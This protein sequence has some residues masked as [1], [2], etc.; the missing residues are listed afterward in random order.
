MTSASTSFSINSIGTPFGDL[1][2]SSSSQSVTVSQSDTITTQSL[3]LLK[4]FLNQASPGI[5]T[6]LPSI[7]FNS[8][9]IQ[10]TQLQQRLWGVREGTLDN[11][12]LIEG[13]G[14]GESSEKNVLSPGKSPLIPSNQSDQKWLTFADGN[15]MWSQAQSV[16]NLPGYKSYA[17]GVQ[18]GATYQ[19]FKGFQVGPYVG[20]QG[21]RVN[22]G[23]SSGNSSAID[24]SVRYGLFAEYSKGGFYAD[25]IAGGAYN[26]LTVNHD[27]SVGNAFSSSA[28]GNLS[29]G[30]FDSLLG[31]GYNFKA[32]PLSFGPMSSLQ[33]TYLNLGSS[34]ETGEG[35]LNLA[36]GSQNAS[37][38]LYTLG[39]QVSAEISLPWQLQ[40][41]PFGSLA[42]QHEFLQDGYTLNYSFL[43][44]NI[45]YQ[46]ANSGRDQYIAALGGN[47]VITRSLSLYAVA[48]LINGDAK[49]FTQSV[50]G[51]I[52][53]KF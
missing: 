29:G 32:G 43:G 19:P 37:S 12:S 18:V 17:G 40:L 39:G 35:V 5:Y 45:G 22:F 20:Y 7:L 8:D 31:T 48:N 9:N 41:Q 53:L 13:Q 28:N 24:N 34:Q 25:G 3:Q 1:V 2:T 27:I 15:G 26:S 50:S 21:T 23:Q 30:E 16:N 4:N 49:V 14:D 38:L 46:T 42:W 47:L 36:V 51:G 52:Q 11:S 44:E 10:N 6:A 33:Y